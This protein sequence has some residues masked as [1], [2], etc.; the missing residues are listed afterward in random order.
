[1]TCGLGQRWGETASHWDLGG[2]GDDVSYPT[3][4]VGR[5][6]LEEQSRLTEMYPVKAEKPQDPMCQDWEGEGFV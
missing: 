2:R 5:P 1:M 4:S 3:L 6:K